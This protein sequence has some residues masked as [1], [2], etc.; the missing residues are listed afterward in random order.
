MNE[1]QNAVIVQLRKR[2]TIKRNIK[3]NKKQKFRSATVVV[4]VTEA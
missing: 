2:K 1:S 4:A 3:K